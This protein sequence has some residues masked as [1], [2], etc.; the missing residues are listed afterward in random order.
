MGI[1]SIFGFKSKGV[2][3][4][5]FLSRGA[6]IVD[7]RTPQEFKDGHVVNSLNIPVQQIEARVS[8]IKKKDKPVILCCK[9][10]GRAAR[11]KSILEN[12]GIE[13]VNAGSWGS[14]NYM[15]H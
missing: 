7:V 10:G 5:E 6:I 2:K 9:S 3:V 13:C 15:I 4:K 12:N 14:L 11:A 8:T 1:L